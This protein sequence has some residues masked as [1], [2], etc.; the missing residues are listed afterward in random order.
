MHVLNVNMTLDPVT[1]GG[2]A[3]RTF[4]MSCFLAKS[5]VECTVLSTDLGWSPARARAFAGVEVI[6]LPCLWKRF[7]L[8]KAAF[9]RIRDAVVR[10]DVVHLMG[11]WTFLNALVYLFAR[12]FRKPY[13]VCSAGALPIYGRSKVLKRLYNFLIGKKIV[14][15]ADR[16]IAVTK[17]ERAHFEMYGVDAD[18]ITVIPNG[19]DPE[20]YVARDDAAFREQYRLGAQPFILF[21]GRLNRIKGPD[22]LLKAFCELGQEFVHYH[23][24]FAGPDEDMRRELQLLASTCSMESR[25]HFIGHVGGDDKARAYH[26]ADLV[27]VPSRQEAMSI[28]VLEAG[29]TGRPLLVTDQ[30]GF[31]EIARIN[32]GRVVPASAEGLKLGLRAML[33]DQDGLKVMGR[34][35]QQFVRERFDWKAIV[36][37]YLALYQ[38]ILNNDEKLLSSCGLHS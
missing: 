13:V 37:E 4:Q 33:E 26:A 34:N 9:K 29:I 32:A 3:E 28:V 21:V 27:V 16:C 11:H 25:V 12:R 15:Q 20:E 10:A 38:K 31:D 36:N 1:G 7:Y 8:P 30:C 6:T 2:T 5:G 22:L 18:R 19:I 23:L 14:R 17:N 24:V 35:L